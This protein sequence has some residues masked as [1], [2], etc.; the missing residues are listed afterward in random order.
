MICKYCNSE[1]VYKNGNRNGKQRYKCINCGKYF[2]TNEIANKYE[3]FFHFNTKLRKT[4]FNKLTKDNYCLKINEIDNDLKRFMKKCK[5]RLR[6]CEKIIEE[7][8]EVKDCIN[9]IKSINLLYG[10]LV[11]I[12]NDIFED[13]EHY[14]KKYFNE[15]YEKRMENFKL[16]MKYFQNLEDK[17][18]NEYIASFVKKHKFIEVKDLNML[19][20]VCGMYILILDEYKQA[21]IGI[22]G[23]IRKRIMKHWSDR[24]A[25]SKLI[26]GSVETSILSIDSFGALDTTRIFYKENYADEEKI[27]NDFKKEYRLNR[28]AGGLNAEYDTNLRNLTLHSTIQERKLK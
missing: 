19:K 23:D 16:N 14:T 20:G 6:E 9:A 22:S 7:Y 8:G 27:V 10:N 21:Y 11:N 13:E 5:N 25:F 28:V 2:T 3:Y 26:Y 24:K 1:K 12:P 15:A 4:D 17:E 18:F